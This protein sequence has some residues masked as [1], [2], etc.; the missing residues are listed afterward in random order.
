MPSSEFLKKEFL[1]TSRRAIKNYKKAGFQ[2]VIVQ[3]YNDEK[4][5]FECKKQNGKVIAINDVKISKNIP[6]FDF[7]KN[8]WC[9]CSLQVKPIIQK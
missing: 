4:T 6:P 5:C 7:C 8:D 3:A 1:K 2:F 9:R